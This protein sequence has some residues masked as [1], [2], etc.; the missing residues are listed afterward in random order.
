MTYIRSQLA[1]S[2]VLNSATNTLSSS[3]SDQEIYVCSYSGNMTIEL[4]SASSV[5]AGFKYIFKKTN[6]VNHDIDISK[7][8]SS[9]DT[10][11]GLTTISMGNPYSSLTL[12]SD[13]SSTFYLI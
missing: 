11:D 8:S 13:G 3:S 5:G 7:N 1:S 2:T 4:Q 9:S 10:I 12:V 6:L